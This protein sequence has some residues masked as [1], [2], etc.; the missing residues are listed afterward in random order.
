MK[1]PSKSCT[2]LLRFLREQGVELPGPDR[3]WRIVRTRA[4]YW[5]RSAG[6]WSWSLEWRSDNGDLTGAPTAAYHSIGSQYSVSECL[7]PGACLDG[8]T[9]YPVGSYGA[10][11]A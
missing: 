4:G 7:K 6:A 2:R 9:I 1:H 3:H 10:V 8:D 11:E 5:Q